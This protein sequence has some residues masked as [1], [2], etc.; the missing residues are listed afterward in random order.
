MKHF[1]LIIFSIFIF[2]GCTANYKN[3]DLKNHT[4][5]DN[6]MKKLAFEIQSLSNSIDKKESE[7]V[8]YDAITYSKHLANEYEVVGPALFH[9]TLINMNIKSRGLCYHYANDLL[10][11][12]KKKEYKSFKFIKT[13]ASRDDYFEHSSIALTT[14]NTHFENSII[15]D[16]WRNTGELYFSKVKDDKRYKWEIK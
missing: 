8:A 13:I 11:Y 7:Q 1:L 9:N 15:L 10:K 14:N 6:N 4:K 5:L 2:A 3:I 16:A 12:L